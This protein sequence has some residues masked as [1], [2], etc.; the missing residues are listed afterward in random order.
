[1]FRGYRRFAAA[2]ETA[3][4]KSRLFARESYPPGAARHKWEELKQKGLRPKR[5]Y[6]FLKEKVG[7]KNFSAC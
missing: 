7:K 2:S 3:Q 5:P 6:F 1:M 4:I